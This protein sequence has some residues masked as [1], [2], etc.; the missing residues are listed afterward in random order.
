[1]CRAVLW[2]LLSLCAV[3]GVRARQ[4]V[5]HRVAHLGSQHHGRSPLRAAPR[6][7]HRLALGAALGA[8]LRRLTRLGRSARLGG[9]TPGSRSGFV[10]SKRNSDWQRAAARRDGLRALLANRAVHSGE[11]LEEEEEEEGGVG[12]ASLKD[13]GEESHASGGQLDAHD[14][15]V[16]E[17]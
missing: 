3:R 9:P 13:D 1:M 4:V 12:R 14:E 7:R 17:M 2:F 16:D 8:A 11:A 5:S 15:D 6:Q 10:A